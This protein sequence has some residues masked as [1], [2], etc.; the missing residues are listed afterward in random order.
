MYK[1]TTKETYMTCTTETFSRIIKDELM[2]TARR[3]RQRHLDRSPFALKSAHHVCKEY[4][5]LLNK[6]MCYS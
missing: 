1:K 3:S 5:L 4:L 2:A 6:P